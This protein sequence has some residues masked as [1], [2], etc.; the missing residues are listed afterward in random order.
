MKWNLFKRPTCECGDMCE[1]SDKISLGAGNLK[2][3][4]LGSG[5][6]NC[7]T[8][9]ENTKQAINELN[10]SAN[11]EYITDFGVIASYG[12]MSVPALVINESVVSSG[13]VL[14]KT[15]ICEILNKFRYNEI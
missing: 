12:V 15:Q 3:K 13:A 4:I 6:K 1:N 11:A 14:T 9:F 2:I 5:C 8:L 10:L 7:K